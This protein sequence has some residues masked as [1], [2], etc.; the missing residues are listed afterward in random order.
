MILKPN[1]STWVE[2][3]AMIAGFNPKFSDKPVSLGFA[4]ELGS[5]GWE[6]FNVVD[7]I[8]SGSGGT[9]SAYFFK[10]EIL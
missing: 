2:A 9:T 5:E 1:G 3:G 7:Y 8:T 6:M 10:R 4:D